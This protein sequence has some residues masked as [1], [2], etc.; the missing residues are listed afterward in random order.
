MALICTFLYVGLKKKCLLNKMS[1]NNTYN[2]TQLYYDIK[3]YE[4]L[5]GS[6]IYKFPSLPHN[7]SWKKKPQPKVIW[8]KNK[9]DISNEAKYRMFSKQGVLTL[10]IRKPCPFD[11]GVYTCKAVNDSGEDT[12][13]CKLEVRCEYVSLPSARTISQTFHSGK[14]DWNFPAIVSPGG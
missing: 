12:V 3:K 2:N 1:C 13:E 10:E 8:Y 5:N 9:V 14:T 7:S 6:Q 11:G 4:V